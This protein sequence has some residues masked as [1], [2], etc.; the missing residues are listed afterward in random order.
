MNAK[1][2]K[3]FPP[4]RCLLAALAAF[5]ALNAAGA[6]PERPV[7]M[8]VPFPP[9]GATDVIARVIAQELS[10][11]LG[12]QVVVE[13]RAG[14][15]GNIGADLVAKSAPDGYT[16]LLGALTSH[17]INVT[18][19]QGKLPYDLEKDFAPVSI[20]GVVPLVFVVHPSVPANSLKELIALAKARPGYLTY[21]SS[22]QGGPQHL[23]GEL[24]QRV[25]GVQ[26][27]H[28]PY[29]GSGPAMTDLI[30]GQVL[31]MIETAPAA[32]PFIKSGKLRALAAASA[33]RIPN[34]TEVPTATEAG[35]P[36][37]EVSS[38]FGL[39][40][41]A[42]TPRAVIQRLNAEVVRILQVPEVK[43]KMLQQGVVA[44]PTTPEQAAQ[45]IHDEVAKWAKVIRE[46]NVKAE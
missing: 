10:G 24:F 34:L 3:A 40:A 36:G 16:L 28:V 29:K 1:I 23:A 45:R 11:P 13:N 17:S 27:L 26:L 5:A 21:A 32:M 9:G 19:Q 39:V 20:A 14:A 33:Q 8:I 42:G 22:G 18:L 12:Q 30:G 43:E 6:W 15:T 31:T 25:A 35:L 7:R 46:A 41:P 44:M 38:M 4:V 37:Y 2:R